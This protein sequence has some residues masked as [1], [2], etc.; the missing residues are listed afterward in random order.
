M[1]TAASTVRQS[2]SRPPVVPPVPQSP[3]TRT[4]R[5]Q[6]PPVTQVSTAARTIVTKTQND[7]RAINATRSNH[8]E[9]IARVLTAE[10]TDLAGRRTQM[11]PAAWEE[12]IRVSSIRAK[13]IN[14]LL[15]EVLGYL[16][17]RPLD[18]DRILAALMKVKNPEGAARLRQGLD[19]LRAA[20]V[21]DCAAA[22]TDIESDPT[23]VK[24]A[25]MSFEEK[26]QMLI[27]LRSGVLY[28]PAQRRKAALDM[29]YKQLPLDPVF[30]AR[31]QQMRNQVLNRLR[32]TL[33]QENRDWETKSTAER[34]DALEW[35]IELQCNVMGLPRDARPTLRLFH[36]EPVRGSDGKVAYRT[37]GFLPSQGVIEVSDRHLDKFDQVLKTVIHENTH[38]YQFWLIKQLEQGKIGPNHPDYNQACMFLLNRDAYQKDGTGVNRP[39]YLGQPVEKHAWLAGLEAARLF[40]ADARVQAIEL[41]KRMQDFSKQA[42]PA[43]RARLD[44]CRQQL[45]DL[46]LRAAAKPDDKSEVT[47]TEIFALVDTYGEEFRAMSPP[48]AT[49][50]PV[51]PNTSPDILDSLQLRLN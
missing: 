18:H 24:L 51:R 31:D 43:Q 34:V 49:T 15:P 46:L 14:G 8:A 7:I 47:S 29:L 41:V 9:E 11:S 17:D 1:A 22:V 25:R 40:R 32:N 45:I 38:N 16:K 48:P 39:V 3:L 23:G 19:R 12:A 37:G 44:V 35:A 6:D 5:T 28:R 13:E 42:T 20:A 26:A 10:L 33:S 30:A 50:T 21:Q 36:A 4:R 2:P 27:A